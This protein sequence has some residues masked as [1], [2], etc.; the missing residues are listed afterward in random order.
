[1]TECQI[2]VLTNCNRCDIICSK[3]CLLSVVRQASPSDWLASL[4]SSVA[5]LL[6]IVEWNWFDQNCFVRRVKSA[7]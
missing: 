1:M 7:C 2:E 4:F 6:M 5:L 3:S